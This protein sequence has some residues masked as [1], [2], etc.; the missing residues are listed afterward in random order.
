MNRCRPAAAAVDAV[1]VSAMAPGASAVANTVFG[2]EEEEEADPDAEHVVVPAAAAGKAGYSASKAMAGLEETSG[3]D[4]QPEEGDKP[5]RARLEERVK[6][7][8]A[9]VA[10]KDAKISEL[11]AAAGPGGSADKPG[12][13]AESESRYNEAVA[14]LERVK[15]SNEEALKALENKF[16]AEREEEQGA[17]VRMEAAVR[18]MESALE[19]VESAAG[20]VSGA[21]SRCGSFKLTGSNAIDP[22]QTGSSAIDPNQT[23]SNA[24]DPNQT[25]SNAIDL[26]QTGSNAID[27]NQT[28]SN[29]IDR[30]ESGPGLG[31]GVVDDA[32]AALK[33]LEQAN[34]DKVSE[35]QAELASLRER[36]QETKAAEAEHRAEIEGLK[37][38][39][40]IAEQKGESASRERDVAQKERDVLSEEVTRLKAQIELARHEAKG[41]A[42]K[43]QSKSGGCTVQ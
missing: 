29:A 23:G 37:E 12:V 14:E 32:G 26:N 30:P 22:N 27:L 5:E 28:G 42:A 19:R 20:R 3:G 40:A 18:M 43:Q 35:A 11:E 7:L 34:Q 4:G 41:D 1:A 36:L 8:V 16:N 33:M 39:H 24:I 6:E 31:K 9:D 13:D 17:L 10:A 25:G 2:H 21:S 38:R 15:A